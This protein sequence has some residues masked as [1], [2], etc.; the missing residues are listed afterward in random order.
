M[1]SCIDLLR[2]SQHVFSDDDRVTVQHKGKS[3]AGQQGKAHNP[4]SKPRSIYSF[5]P[6]AEGVAEECRTHKEQT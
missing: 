5:W 1:I 3:V 2:M 6:K 4:R